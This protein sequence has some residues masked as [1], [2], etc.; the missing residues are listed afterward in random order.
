MVRIEWARFD[1][2]QLSAAEKPYRLQGSFRIGANGRHRCRILSFA[3]KEQQEYHFGPQGFLSSHQPL[4][5][6]QRR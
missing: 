6:L 4:V 1:P 5:A 3:S 2:G